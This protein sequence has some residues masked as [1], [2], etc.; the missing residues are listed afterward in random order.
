MKRI[1]SNGGAGSGKLTAPRFSM[2]KPE[3]EVSIGICGFS[4]KILNRVELVVHKE[5]FS[6]QSKS[7]II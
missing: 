2:V 6:D 3:R 7:F 1:G 5:T 4:N